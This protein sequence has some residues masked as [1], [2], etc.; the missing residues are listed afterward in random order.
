MYVIREKERRKKGLQACTNP[1]IFVSHISTNYHWTTSH[2]SSL[3]IRCEFI[4]E[5]HYVT[6]RIHHYIGAIMTTMASQISS[7]T[8]VY[9]TVYSDANQRKHQSSASLAFHR[10]KGQLRVKCFHLMTSSCLGYLCR[11]P[12]NVARITWSR[13]LNMQARR[14]FIANALEL[15]LFHIKPSISNTDQT[16]WAHPVCAFNL[17]QYLEY[18]NVPKKT[19]H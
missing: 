6:L 17:H 14:N 9:S 18:Y 16:Q 15:R 7:L 2:C 10:T 4:C 13:W 12:N 8:V 11:A 19:P 1:D 3:G 5:D